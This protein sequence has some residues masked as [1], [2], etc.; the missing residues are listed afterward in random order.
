M[1]ST[2]KI[3]AIEPEG[4]TT[5]LVIGES[6][7]NTVISNNDIRA[8][9]LQDAGG[10]AVFTSNGS[11]V[12]S[13][14][15]S[16]FGSAMV[17]LSTQTA[18]GSASLS[19]TSGIDSTYGEYIFKFYNINPATDAAIFSFQV[20]ASGQSGYNETITST[21]FRAEHNQTG[22]DSALGYIADSD[23]AE[24]TAY[25]YLVYSIGSGADENAAGELH[26]FN[27]ASTTYAKHFY[28]R[29]NAY[30]ASNY[31]SDYY[32]GGYVNTT[33]AIDDIQ[34]KMTSGNFDGE[35]KMWG[36]K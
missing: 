18:S 23:Q 33:S 22:A 6:G 35:I 7:Q 34:F 17:L 3:N 9:V 30:H 15:N 16:G 28:S 4:A 12:L 24:G 8:N 19:F 10:N 2:L 14:V 25:Q 31:S 26:L 29:F 27:P 11:G 1:T 21:F 32:A 20:N 13:G 5:N 36:V